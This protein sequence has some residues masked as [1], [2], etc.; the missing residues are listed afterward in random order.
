ML[1]S[2]VNDTNNRLPQWLQWHCTLLDLGPPMPS[3]GDGGSRHSNS[4]DSSS[5]GSAASAN[6]ASGSLP[7]GPRSGSVSGNSSSSA[8]S[9]GGGTDVD[10]L[11]IV[12]DLLLWFQLTDS[13]VQGAEDGDWK[14]VET[15]NMWRAVFA[16]L[17][18]GAPAGLAAFAAHNR[19]TLALMW[20]VGYACLMDKCF[21]RVR[22]LK[23]LCCL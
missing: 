9:S 23:S 16:G 15:L 8:S 12:Q 14:T 11:V 13:L 19:D 6:G 1:L 20:R 22:L 2:A 5:R 21:M 4:T 10:P 3:R 7:S 18:P 17:Q